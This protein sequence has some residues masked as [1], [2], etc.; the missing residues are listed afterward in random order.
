MGYARR[1]KGIAMGAEENKAVFRRYVEEVLNK[2]NLDAVDEL[3]D[4]NVVSTSPTQLRVGKPSTSASPRP[5]LH[6]QTCESR[7]ID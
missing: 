3:C 6:F 5:S 4:E 2:R 1:G 7:S